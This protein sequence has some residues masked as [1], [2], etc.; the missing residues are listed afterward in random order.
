[1]HLVWLLPFLCSLVPS[2]QLSSLLTLPYFVGLHKD[3]FDSSLWGVWF[4]IFTFALTT[5][6]SLAGGLAILFAGQLVRRALA[7]GTGIA[8][9]AVVYNMLFGLRTAQIVACE[10]DACMEQR[11]ACRYTGAV[12]SWEGTLF[13]FTLCT[14]ICSLSLSLA[15]LLHDFSSAAV[16]EAL[17]LSVTHD[18]SPDKSNKGLSDT[19]KAGLIEPVFVPSHRNVLTSNPHR[20]SPQQE[21]RGATSLRN[22]R[23]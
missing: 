2:T 6:M 8:L 4:R 13:S 5:A 16:P 9:A 12:R 21:L 18:N 15:V 3:S 10:T 20:D 19:E 7:V 14:L 17:D 22:S 11:S 1:M 23:W